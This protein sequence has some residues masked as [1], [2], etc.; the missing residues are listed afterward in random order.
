MTFEATKVDRLKPQPVIERPV[1]RKWD[2][3]SLLD[4]G[5][6]GVGIGSMWCILHLYS[7]YVWVVNLCDSTGCWDRCQK[8]KVGQSARTRSRLRGGMCNEASFG[9]IRMG[10]SLI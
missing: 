9:R 4:Q 7:M 10:Q 1:M 2:S 8:R 5:A 3:C 6:C